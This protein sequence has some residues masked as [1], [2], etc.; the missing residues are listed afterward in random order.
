MDRTVNESGIAKLVAIT[1]CLNAA[2]RPYDAAQKELD[3][4][5]Q[6]Y[7]ALLNTEAADHVLNARADVSVAQ[8][9]YEF[10]QD[11]LRGCRPG[12]NLQLR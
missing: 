11:Y 12:N 9:R 2:T 4:A 6:A 5:Q 8:E 10:A 3:D 7:D 1:I